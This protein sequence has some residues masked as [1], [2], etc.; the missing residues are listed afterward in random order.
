MEVKGHGVPT[1]PV[2]VTS[3]TPVELSQT[4]HRRSL[5]TC[6]NQD[7]SEASR[8]EIPA[9]IA[10]VTER[11]GSIHYDKEVESLESPVSVE[12]GVSEKSTVPAIY[13]FY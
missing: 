1:E 4:I 7:K 12:E 5:S 2:T 13:S 6:E 11:G 3:T 8:S 9:I 10:P